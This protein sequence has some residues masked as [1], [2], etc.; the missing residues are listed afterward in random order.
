[1]GEGVP[2]ESL[3]G[4]GGKVSLGWAAPLPQV[5]PLERNLLSIPK[6]TILKPCDYTQCVQ[7]KTQLQILIREKFF[8]VCEIYWIVAV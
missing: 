3:V 2:T 8:G 7:I 4:E 6:C 1:M 5:T